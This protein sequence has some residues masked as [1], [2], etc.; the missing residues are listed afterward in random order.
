MKSSETLLELLGEEIRIRRKRA[1]MYRFQLAEKAG[2]S[3]SHLQSI[4]KGRTSV[5]MCILLSICN[6]LETDLTDILQACWPRYA[7]K[8][9]KK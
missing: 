5:G 2:C 9:G 6:A 4:E 8:K 7:K 1:K 3:C